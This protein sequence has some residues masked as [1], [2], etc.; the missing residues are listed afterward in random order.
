MDNNFDEL[1]LRF[2]DQYVLTNKMPEHREYGSLGWE[3]ILSLVWAIAAV[4]MVASQTASE[5]YQAKILS[6]MNPN[7]AFA[8]SVAVLV[9][10]EGGLVIG[11]AI[12]ASGARAYN[13]NLVIV[14]IGLCV[15]ISVAAGLNSS[16]GI[17]PNLDQ[18]VLYA[19]RVGLV[20]SLGIAGSLVAWASGEVL[21]AQ[22]AKVFI[23]RDQA[24]AEYR[25][26]MQVYNDQLLASWRASPEYVL[27]KAGVRTEADEAKRRRRK[28]KEGDETFVSYGELSES[29]GQPPYSGSSGKDYRKLS[30]EQRNSLIGADTRDIVQAFG[31]SERTAQNWRRFAERDL[32]G[33]NGKDS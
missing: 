8:A 11:A 14:A 17:I 33:G 1:F 27:A 4:V 21:G 23:D 15:L 22:I 19:M 3:F 13:K 32:V 5:F 7:L 16:V 31:I 9:A 20:I 10:I 25:Q 28:A 2:R 6:G 18:G 24:N 29:F 26:A 30:P 12:K